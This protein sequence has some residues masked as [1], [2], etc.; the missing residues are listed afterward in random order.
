MPNLTWVYVFCIVVSLK[1]PTPTTGE[2][3]A[4]DRVREKVSEDDRYFKS[5]LSFRPLFKAGL[6]SEAKFNKRE[7]EKQGRSKLF[8]LIFLIV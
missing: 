1:R 7:A 2:V 3:K 6:I 8:L 4:I 5:L